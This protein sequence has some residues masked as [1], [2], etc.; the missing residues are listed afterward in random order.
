M[1]EIAT[2]VPTMKK[3]EELVRS[4]SRS[5]SKNTKTGWIE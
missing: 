3:M 4:P 5:R 2:E 1:E